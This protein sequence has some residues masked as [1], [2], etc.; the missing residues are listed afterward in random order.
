MIAKQSRADWCFCGV[1]WLL[2]GFPDL[3][4]TDGRTH[5]REGC[6]EPPPP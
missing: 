3:V 5:T 6:H 4:D 1:H 2:P